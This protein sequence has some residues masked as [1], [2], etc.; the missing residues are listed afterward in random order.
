MR[1]QKC[2]FCEKCDFEIVN[3]VKNKFLKVWILWKLRFQKCE[4]CEKWDFESVNFEK[5]ENLVKNVNFKMFEEYSKILILASEAS[6]VNFLKKPLANGFF[7][8]W[9]FFSILR[10]YSI[11]RIGKNL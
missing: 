4:F 1:F 8:P 7:V 10:F 3:F 6:Y 9:K 5:N 2:E 11:K